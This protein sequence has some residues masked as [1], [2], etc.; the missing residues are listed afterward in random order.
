MGLHPAAALLLL[1][2]GILA[3]RT[4]TGLAAILLAEDSGGVAARQLAVWLL[5]LLPVVCA[6]AI[7][8]RLGLFAAP[9]AAAFIVLTGLVSGSAFILRLAGRL[10]GLDAERREMQESRFRLASLVESSDDAIVAETLDGTV[11]HWNS[12]AERL[13]GYSAEE[14]VGQSFFRIVPPDREGE[15]RG[16]LEAIR[17]ERT[18]HAIETVRLRKDGTSI[19]VSVVLSP[20]VDEAGRIV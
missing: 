12:G 6:I 1:T 16:L 2:G 18:F 10:S 8:S 15:L 3:A 14:M 11:T 19:P 20:I 4:E 17:Q 7:S 13:Y 5:V 9:M